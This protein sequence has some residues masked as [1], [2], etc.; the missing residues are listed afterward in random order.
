[1]AL[2][3]GGFPLQALSQERRVSAVKQLSAAG[4]GIQCGS[5]QQGRGDAAGLQRGAAAGGLH[6]GRRRVGR[7]R[8]AADAAL[9]CRGGRSRSRHCGQWRQLQAR[10]P[11]GLS[12]SQ[13]RAL[14]A[15]PSA[16]V[17]LTLD[18]CHHLPAALQCIELSISSMS[19]SIRSRNFAWCVSLIT[20]HYSV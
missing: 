11:A 3:G 20:W 13:A 19:A 15:R 18:Q 16:S 9:T 12:S 8:G 4:R 2:Y 7:R 17:R 6:G 1:M 5:G 10:C 14:P